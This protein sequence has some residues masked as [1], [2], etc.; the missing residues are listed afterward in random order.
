MGTLQS[1]MDYLLD[2]LRGA[3]PVSCRKMFGEYCLYYD[4]SPIGLVCD[5]QLYLK[6]TEEGRKL[7]DVA[8]EGAPF[9]GAR[10]HLLIDADSW[11]DA[12][13]LSLLVRT[14]ALSL[15]VRPDKPIR[16]SA[17]AKATAKPGAS[18]ADLP[19][20]GPKSAALL[21]QIG[22][23]TVAQLRQRGAVA[24]Y[25]TV[26]QKTPSASLNLLWAIEGALS[27]I[28]WQVVAR[29]HRT[30]LLLALEQ[31]ESGNGDR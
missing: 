27:G 9:P 20:L 4:G 18:V 16:K 30:S 8:R 14:T 19:N 22:I 17:A 13:T 7:L 25:A 12:Q 24:A 10:T 28:S 5:N 11:E 29:E 23:R 2:Q 3:G 26:R 6:P 21:E 31:F 1:T 15:P